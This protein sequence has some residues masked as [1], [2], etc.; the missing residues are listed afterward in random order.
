M[1]YQRNLGFSQHFQNIKFLAG[2]DIF[3]SSYWH[4]EVHIQITDSLVWAPPKFRSH[5]KKLVYHIETPCPFMSPL[6]LYGHTSRKFTTFKQKSHKL[7]EI[8]R[9]HCHIRQG[10]LLCMGKGEGDNLLFTPV[11]AY[12]FK[13]FSGLQRSCPDSENNRSAYVMFVAAAA[14][15]GVTNAGHLVLAFSYID[16]N[17]SKKK[18]PFYIGKL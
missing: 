2:C 16:E 12:H 11:T 3:A 7:W 18:S 15:T 13:I 8:Y 5:K 6:T 1:L 17:S 14:L 9:I 10:G 4:L